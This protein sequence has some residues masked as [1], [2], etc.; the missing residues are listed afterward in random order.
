LVAI[1]A[2]GRCEAIVKTASGGFAAAFEALEAGDVAGFEALLRDEPDLARERG[3]N[4]NTLLNLAVSLAGKPGWKAGLSAVQALLA[5]GADVNEANDRGGTP[6]HQAGYSNQPVMANVLIEH[7]AA[8]DVEAYGAGGTPLVF[9]LFWGHR[10]VAEVL[11]AHAIV[12]RNLRVAAGLGD[13]KLVDACFNADASLTSEAVAARGFYRPHRGF[14]EWEPSDDRQEVLDE[15]LVWA[16]KS[17]R[18]DVLATLIEA[19]AWLDADPYR[20]TPLIWAAVCNRVETAAW[21]LDHGAHI[22]KKATFGGETH[23]QGVTALHMAAQYGHLAV[24]KLLVERGADRTIKEDLYDSTPR[25]AAAY[26][27]QDEVREYLASLDAS[28]D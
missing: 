8:L 17:G 3:L 16:C 1:A 23:G 11:A 7:G 24:I 20:G 12:P 13:A 28:H 5:A 19:G 21:L 2:R 9:A 26:F 18:V 27:G 4:G 10:E 14:P 15:A 22:D 25:G 6:L